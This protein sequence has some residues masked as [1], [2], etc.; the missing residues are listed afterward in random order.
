MARIEEMPDHRAD[1]EHDGD[2]QPIETGREKQRIVI[3][4]HQKNDRKC[5]VVV[6]HR[7]LLAERTPSWIGLLSGEHRLD[8]LLLIRND[9]HKDVRH[10]DG[11]DKRAD[12]GEGAWPLKTCVNP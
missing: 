12:L 1:G 3:A 8:G 11:A 7:A 2:D 5:Q 4:Q 9:D 10:H 6:V